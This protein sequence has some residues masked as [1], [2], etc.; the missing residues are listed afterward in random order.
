[1]TS[2]LLPPGVTI[3]SVSTSTG[4]SYELT[5]PGSG[6]LTSSM[7]LDG[8]AIARSFQQSALRYAR[9]NKSA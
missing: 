5:P 6:T 9:R 3:T 4:T 7:Q 8:D 2:A 1:M